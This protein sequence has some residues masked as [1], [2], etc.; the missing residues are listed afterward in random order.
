MTR[1]NWEISVE[2]GFLGNE[3]WSMIKR[4]LED[5]GKDK[6]FEIVRCTENVVLLIIERWDSF[7]RLQ[8]MITASQMSQLLIDIIKF[9]DDKE[10][11]GLKYGRQKPGCSTTFPMLRT[12]HQTRVPSTVILKLI[13]NILIVESC[14]S[15]FSFGNQKITAWNNIAI[16][17]QVWFVNKFSFTLQKSF[18]NYSPLQPLKSNQIHFKDTFH[19][20]SISN[21]ISFLH[22]CT[23]L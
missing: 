10:D 3:T 8:V 7:K 9:I 20:P 13:E 18:Q 22:F 1:G 2:Q 11:K 14:Q 6:R 19:L 15:N 17:N 16:K 12:N 5:G 23:L 4:N 21:Y